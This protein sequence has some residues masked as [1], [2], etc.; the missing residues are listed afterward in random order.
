[1]REQYHWY[2][3]YTNPRAEKKTY[4]QLVRKSIEVYLPLKKTLKQWSD[5]KK[6]VQEPFNLF[7]LFFRYGSDFA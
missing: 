2:P 4:E 7:Y 3:V 1:M 6:W 5:R